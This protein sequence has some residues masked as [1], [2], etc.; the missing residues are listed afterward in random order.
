[1]TVLENALVGMHARLRGGPIEAV[2]RPPWIVAEERQARARADDLLRMVGLAG[3]SEE[4][5][6]GLP[7]GLQRR[8]ELARALATRPRL[9][10]LDEPTAGM[11][12]QET[13]D[14][15]RLV[16]RVRGDLGLTILL[17]E[18]DM[19]V[20]MGISDR[21]SVL[22]HG[23]LIAEGT[24]A[25]VQGNPRVIEAYLGRRANRTA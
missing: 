8:L 15:T 24:P 4:W 12:P 22:D 17:I 16:Q 5:A 2:L 3:H 20:V 11:N 10:L 14:L 9:L 13:V 23:V 6:G 19:R 18:H 7:Y 25:E 1:M 21:V